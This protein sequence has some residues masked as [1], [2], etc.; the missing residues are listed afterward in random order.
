[1]Y[2]RHGGKSELGGPLAT[3]SKRSV[4]YCA[5]VVLLSVDDIF[6]I[7][8]YCLKDVSFGEHFGHTQVAR[9]KFASFSWLFCMSALLFLNNHDIQAVYL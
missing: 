8:M 3:S 7:G 5:P 2:G 6:A 1:M 4:A 9:V